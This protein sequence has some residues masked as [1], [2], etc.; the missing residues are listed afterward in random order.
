MKKWWYRVHGTLWAEW[1][2]VLPGGYV[3]VYDEEG[4]ILRRAAYGSRWRARAA[5]KVKGFRRMRRKDL[6]EVPP[7]EIR[8]S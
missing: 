7:P 1:A 5:L 3:L 8:Q 2:L 4:R 6:A